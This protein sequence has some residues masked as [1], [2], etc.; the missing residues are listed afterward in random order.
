[1]ARHAR[2]LLGPPGVA[3]QVVGPVPLLHVEAALVGVLPGPATGE[4]PRE[5]RQRTLERVAQ[6]PRVVPLRRAT[7]A[8]P[9]AR[10]G[11]QTGPPVPRAGVVDAGATGAPH[12]LLLAVA[13]G[14]ALPL[15]GIRAVEVPRPPRV[16]GVAAVAATGPAP[17]PRTVGAAP[18]APRVGEVRHLVGVRHMVAMARRRPRPP[19][20]AV[21]PRRAGPPTPDQ[22]SR[23]A[24]ARLVPRAMGAQRGDEVPVPGV[25]AAPRPRPA[26]VADVAATVRGAHAHARVRTKAVGVVVS[27][28]GRPPPAVR[29][30]VVPSQPAT[31]PRGAAGV[32]ANMRRPTPVTVVP[33]APPRKAATPI[34]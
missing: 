14:A 20:R 32:L 10:A 24:A 17:R 13:G 12:L 30:G 21:R 27:V 9:N 5:P 25:G 28:R 22:A 8:A 18:A 6:W 19:R 31:K 7:P 11:P 4:P 29:V 3:P 15:A 16:L 2:A 33:A 1:M 34:A 23:V 26:R